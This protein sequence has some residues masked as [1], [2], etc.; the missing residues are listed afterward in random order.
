MALLHTTRILTI[1]KE[2]KSKNGLFF[3]NYDTFLRKYLVDI[4]K[5]HTFAHDKE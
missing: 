4:K 3:I 5:C 2:I 1:Y